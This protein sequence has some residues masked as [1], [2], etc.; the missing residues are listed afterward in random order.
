[1][2]YTTRDAALPQFELTS[3]DN[4]MEIDDDETYGAIQAE[5]ASAGANGATKLAT[6][7]GPA[8]PDSK[9]R[10]NQNSVKTIVSEEVWSQ[11]ERVAEIV[12]AQSRG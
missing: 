2:D 4:K 5:N 7:A 8:N 9:Q 3:Q 11:M 10:S 12:A 6:S 1:V